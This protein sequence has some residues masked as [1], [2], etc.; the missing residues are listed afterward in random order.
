MQIRCA[1][2]VSTTVPLIIQDNE[3]RQR[4]ID[5]EVRVDEGRQAHL[6]LDVTFVLYI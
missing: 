6:S 4:H 1:S 5:Q 3:A 2:L